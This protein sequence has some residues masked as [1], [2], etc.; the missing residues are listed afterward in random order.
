MFLSIYHLQFTIRAARAVAVALVLLSPAA[1]AGTR[2]GM[3][4][5]VTTSAFTASE[6]IAR[7]KTVLLN[8]E[9]VGSRR[10]DVQALDGHITLT[11]RVATREERD[12]AVSLTRGVEGVRSVTSELAIQP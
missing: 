2:L 4:S 7:I 9:I 5:A 11:G 12:R 6:L 10:I 8:D 3:S 1:C